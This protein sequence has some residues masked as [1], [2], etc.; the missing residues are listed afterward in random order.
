MSEWHLSNGGDAFHFYSGWGAF[1]FRLIP[2]IAIL[3]SLG[4]GSIFV[5]MESCQKGL[6]QAGIEPRDSHSIDF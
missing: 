4:F 2:F 5:E 6:A 3:C 1:A